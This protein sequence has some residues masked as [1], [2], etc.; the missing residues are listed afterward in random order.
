MKKMFCLSLILLLSLNLSLAGCS[1]TKLASPHGSTKE[2]GTLIIGMESDADLLDPHRAGGWVTMRVNNQMFEPLIGEDLSKSSQEAPVPELIPV[3]AEK[4][5]KS[6]D[7][8]TYTFDLRKNVKFHD[9][10]PFNADAVL[11]NIQRLTNE[12]FQYY[13]KLAAGRT[14]RTFKYFDSAEVV[15]DD[16][17][18]IHLKQPFADFPRM[19]A[20]I[21]SLQIVSPDAI[22]KYG[23][24][25]FGEHPS[26]TGPFTFSE[27]KRGVQITLTKNENYWGTKAYL[28][29][30]IFRPLSDASSR[31]LALQNDDV[32]LIAVPPPDSIENFK[33]QGYHVIS[34]TPPHVWYLTFNFDND[35]MKNK[36]V[37]QAINYAIDRRGL[38]KHLLRDTASPAYSMMSPGSPLYDPQENTYEYNPEKA[39]QLLKEAGYENGFRTILKTSVDG[40]GQL[41]PVDMAEWIQRD[42][43]KIGIKVSLQT[44]EWI[45]YLADYNNGMSEEI[46]MNQMSSGRTTPY[47]LAIASHSDYSAPGGFNS[48]KYKN[49][50][51]DKKMDAAANTASV[52]DANQLWK[53]AEK[54]IIEDAPFAPIVNDSA[55]YVVHP[56]V[57]DFVVPAEEWYTLAPVWV[58]KE[59]N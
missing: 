1:Q 11:F 32:D 59:E 10:T 3:L 44:Q 21:N 47:F 39:K 5:E 45:S 4:W 36:K 34:G 9:G 41:I 8:K 23:N 38:T 24:D 51:L 57:Q 14:V 19:L 31:V 18:N 55:P 43:G 27:R 2:G 28:D 30:V 46:G 17:I 33:N 13:D 22:K 37:R 12:N 56:R 35:Y 48:G 40:S 25:G 49:K 58:K 7:G 6:A 29:K 50:V 16:T 15:D 20:Q 42:L 26:G 54:M 52:E 53:E